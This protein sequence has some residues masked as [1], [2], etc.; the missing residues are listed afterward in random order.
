MSLARSL[1]VFATGGLFKLGVGAA[2]RSL[3][4]T[5]GKADEQASTLAGMM[6]VQAGRRSVLLL[7]E[8]LRAGNTTP[9]LATIL[10]DLGGPEAE[11]ELRRLAGNGDGPLVEAAQRSLKDLEQIRRMNDG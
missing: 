1:G 3:V 6:L 10:G 11:A 2:G 8:A 5:V 9:A 4:E 7:I